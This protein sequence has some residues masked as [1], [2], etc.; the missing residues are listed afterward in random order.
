MKSY[1]DYIY[2]LKQFTHGG[3]NIK[4]L[5]EIN[6]GIINNIV[7]ISG[8]ENKFTNATQNFKVMSINIRKVWIALNLNS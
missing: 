7:E 3:I 5:D 8:T 2:K 1:E 4:K 6:S